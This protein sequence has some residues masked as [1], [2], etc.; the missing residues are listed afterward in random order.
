MCIRDRTYK[1]H[2]GKTLSLLSGFLIGSLYKVWPW[3]NVLMERIN[4]HGEKV[5][6]L[7]KNVM[8]SNYQGNANLLYCT[9]LVLGGFFMVFI[10]ENLASQKDE[11]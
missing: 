5:P 10:F 3:Q 8:P 9:I 4:S 2:K 6:W 11:D 7:M 1:N